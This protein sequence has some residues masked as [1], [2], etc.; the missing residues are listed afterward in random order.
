MDAATLIARAA[1]RDVRFEIEDGELFIDTAEELKPET[2][3]YF[4]RHKSLLLEYLSRAPRVYLDFEAASRLDLKLAGSSAYAEHPSTRVLLLCY[5]IGDGLVQ[6][7][8]PGNPMP[9]DLRQ[10]IEA[11]ATCVAHNVSFDLAIWQSH[12][13][14]LG[15]PELPWRRWSDTA[16]R[17]RH[18][19][20]PAALKGAGEV[21]QLAQQKDQ[22][23]KLLMLRLAKQAYVGGIEPTPE[24]LDR[25]EP[26]CARDVEVMREIDRH[27]QVPELT[28]EA[29]SIA[30]MNQAMNRR[31][32]PVD[33]TWCAS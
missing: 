1:E 19:R 4:R 8:R 33:P 12:Q 30:E 26:Y 15:W 17:A 27:P 21:L 9:E 31:G 25:L 20:L 23:G 29:P 13:V 32:M 7:W 18:A 22:K 16:S 14:P 11:G 5:A 28:G 6:T 2:L 10:A 3:S 24:E